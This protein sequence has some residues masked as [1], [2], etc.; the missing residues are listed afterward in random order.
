MFSTDVKIF[1]AKSAVRNRMINYGSI[2]DRLS[3]IVVGRGHFTPVAIADNVTA[4]HIS[5][6]G[7]LSWFMLMMRGISI[8][9]FKSVSLVTSQDPFELGFL[10]WRTAKR[11]GVPIQLQIHTDFLSPY[12]AK[13]FV[14]KVRVL[15]ARLLLPRADC[16]RV[17]SE[18]IKQS[19]QTTNYRLQTEPVVLP[20]YVDIKKIHNA[21]QKFSLRDKY[22]QFDFI[23]LSV[24]RQTIEK[25][26]TLA[27]RAFR[28]VVVNHPKAGLVIVGSGPE[29]DRLKLKVIQDKLEANVVFEEWQDDLVSYYKSAD[30]FLLTSNYEGFGMALVEAAAA[31]CPIVTTNVGIAGE[32]L[33]DRLS[34]LVCS[35]GDARCLAERLIELEVGGRARDSLV[36]KAE[37][38]INSLSYSE[39]D[40]LS[41]YKAALTQCLKTENQI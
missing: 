17:V 16:I 20:I 7:I 3:I 32:I 34:A 33:K 40:Y 39:A 5:A 6:G 19:L 36:L 26:H 30:A 38:A 15:I 35:V 4:W 31:G 24:G 37:Q 41:R 2:F 21:E 18:R 1:D 12:F 9:E 11:L 8:A 23:V 27:I 25:N 22:P 10:A 14:N 29:G 13:T 28:D